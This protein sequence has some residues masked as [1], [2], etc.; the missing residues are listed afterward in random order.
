MKLKMRPEQ[1]AALSVIFLGAAL[2]ALFCSG[3]LILNTTASVP[4]GLWWRIDGPLTLGDV[5]RVP[6]EAFKAT[7]WVPEVYWRKNAWGRPKA[8]LKRVAGLPGNII[9]AG[10]YG[11]LRINGHLISNSAPLSADRAGR[12]LKAYPLPLQLESDEIWLLSDSPRGFD[13]RYLGPAQLPKNHKFIPLV[14][15]IV[16]KVNSN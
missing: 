15:L 14:T 6:I 16:P 10:E 12:P 9:E 2:A 5:V 7:D 1:R 3:K 13:S 4:I 11:L 8:F